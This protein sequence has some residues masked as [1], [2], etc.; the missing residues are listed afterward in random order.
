M[1]RTSVGV[2]IVVGLV[3]FLSGATPVSAQTVGAASSFAIV[4]GTT[5]TAGGAISTVNGD[6]GVSPGTSVTGFPSPATTVPPYSVHSNDGAAI[7]AQAATLALYNSLAALG[8]A[9]PIPAQLNTQNL[10]PGTYSIGAAD[11]AGG[12]TLTLTGAGTYVFQ[13]AS[14][15]VANVGSQ[16][17]LLGGASACNVFWQ[18]TSAATLNGVNFAGNVVAQAN[19]TL[20][21]GDQLTGRALATSLG[22]VTLSGGN[23]A[24]GCSTAALPPTP[25]PTPPAPRPNACATTAPDLFITKTHVD[26]FVVGSNGTYRIALGNNG[27][28]SIGPITVTDTLPATLAFVSASGTGWTCVVSGQMVSCTTSSTLPGLITLTVTPGANAAPSVTNNA[29]VSGGSDCD[30]TNNTSS[31]SA[32]VATAVPTLSQ[33]GLIALGALLAAVGTVALR[34]RSTV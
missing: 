13:V 18:V 11:L 2:R 16:V 4:G 32:A 21:V 8:P 22:S 19:V 34:R 26:P 24:G 9:T 7:N 10:G 20:G 12:G 30:L 1:T 31:D 23:S 5:V 29:A 15:L 27:V 3:T 6:V 28:T 14:S 33:W 25:T 17:V